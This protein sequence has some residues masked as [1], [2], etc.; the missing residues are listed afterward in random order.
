MR[1][2]LATLLGAVLLGFPALVLHYL[3]VVWGAA[4]ALPL[5]WL[6]GTPTDGVPA[7]W[8]VQVGPTSV[9]TKFLGRQAAYGHEP[10]RCRAA[11]S[12]ELFDVPPAVPVDRVNIGAAWR[13]FRRAPRTWNMRGDETRPLRER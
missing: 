5:A 13:L 11:Y 4:W 2:T 8:S 7:W 6:S 9:S 1:R 10:R 3:L 12:G